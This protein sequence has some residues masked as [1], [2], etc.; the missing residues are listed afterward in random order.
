MLEMED[1]I[2]KFL[3]ELELLYRKYGL[4]IAHE[5]NHG[6]FIIERFSEDNL[7]WI[8]CAHRRVYPK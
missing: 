4:S 5:D 7:E 8:K 6:A 3:D 1:K 2:A